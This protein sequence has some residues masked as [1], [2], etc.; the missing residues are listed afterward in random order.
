MILGRIIRRNPQKMIP[1]TSPG[2][3]VDLKIARSG[4]VPSEEWLADDVQHAMT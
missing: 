3:F 1:S 2:K 4:G